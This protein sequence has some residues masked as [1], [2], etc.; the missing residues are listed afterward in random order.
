VAPESRLTSTRDAARP[1]FFV[2]FD[3]FREMLED[4]AL[5]GFLFKRRDLA[6]AEARPAGFF[7]GLVLDFAL[8]AMRAATY[9]E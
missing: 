9:T 8:V 4:A 3:P 5:T 1:A 7:D 2:V 6:G